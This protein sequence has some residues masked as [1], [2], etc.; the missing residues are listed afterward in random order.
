VQVTIAVV[1]QGQHR[2]VLAIEAIIHHII[3][4]VMVAVIVGRSRHFLF[5]E[6]HSKQCALLV[7]AGLM[8]S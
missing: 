1:S 8:T 6:A 4:A 7:A 3:V 5:A 2:C